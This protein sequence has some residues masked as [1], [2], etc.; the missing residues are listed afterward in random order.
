MDRRADTVAGGLI[1]LPVSEINS[2]KLTEGMG[3]IVRVGPGEKGKSIGLKTG[4]RV[5]FRSFLKHVNPI[6]TTDVWGDVG[7]TYARKRY[8][9]MAIDDIMGVISEGV[10]VGVFSSPAS[11]AIPAGAFDAPVSK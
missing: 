7:D 5:A 8:F 1:F 11:H 9:L 2:E 10:N 3:T 4:D 6:D